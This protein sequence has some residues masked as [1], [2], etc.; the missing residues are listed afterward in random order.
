MNA[1]KTVKIRV[2]RNVKERHNEALSVAIANI[3]IISSN[4]LK[5]DNER[6]RLRFFFFDDVA[7]LSLPRRTMIL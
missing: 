4:F 5:Y 6:R 3:K 7:F 2:L 1:K